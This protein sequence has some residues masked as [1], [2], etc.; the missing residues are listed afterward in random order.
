MACEATFAFDRR[1]SSDITHPV[2]SGYAYYAASVSNSHRGDRGEMQS[3]PDVKSSPWPSICSTGVHCPVLFLC[4]QA[5][6]S[7]AKVYKG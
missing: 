3:L 2:F 4:L 5:A 7:A 6:M 1:G